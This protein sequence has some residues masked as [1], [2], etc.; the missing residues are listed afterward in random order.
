MEPL[1]QILSK[2]DQI[3]ELLQSTPRVS[4]RV[5]R[6]SN[7][8]HSTNRQ[9]VPGD[10]VLTGPNAREYFQTLQSP[11]IVPLRDL[12]PWTHMAFANDAWWL[13]TLS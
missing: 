3:L 4:A 6:L 10:M 12:P 7:T 9:V 11:T 13:L 1:D 8:T 5:T 2:L